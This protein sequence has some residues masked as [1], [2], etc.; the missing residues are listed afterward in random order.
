MSK[1]KG[2]CK[3]LLGAAVG[4]GLGILFAPQ[5]GKKTRQ[6][7][8]QKLDELI[9]NLKQIDS[10]EIKANIE[11]KIAELKAELADLDKEK[12]LKIA[13]EKAAVVKVKAQELVD[14]AVEKGTPVL[15][16]LADEARE[17]ALKFSKEVV[18]K[19]EAKEKK[20]NKKIAK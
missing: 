11:K 13:K 16:K 9:E 1:K 4:A 15:Q 19:L 7:L 3:F 17:Q 14:L 12:A 10:K 8:K 5:E 20:P 2:F 18:K 6:Q